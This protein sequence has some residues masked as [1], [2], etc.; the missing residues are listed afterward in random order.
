MKQKILL[1]I[2]IPIPTLEQAYSLFLQNISWIDWYEGNSRP[3]FLK[4]LQQ[5]GKPLIN[6][7]IDERGL[8][9]TN[10]NKYI[11]KF[12]QPFEKELYHPERYKRIIDEILSYSNIFNKI[13]EKFKLMNHSWGFY[14][15][16]EYTIDLNMYVGNGIYNANNGHILIGIK[17]GGVQVNLATIK[18]IMHEMIHLGIENILIRDKSGK[19]LL[20]QEEKERIVDNL[21]QYVGKDI[22]DKKLLQ[23]QPITEKCSYIDEFVVGQPQKN[24]VKEIQK[25]LKTK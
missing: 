11:E 16:P 1:N 4:S 6:Q 21:C 24:L 15:F 18:L 8:L 13:H 2:Q 10:K 9:K 19:L 17:G 20:K 3:Y 14:I 7:M 25:F 12:Q 22:F 5:M 23:F